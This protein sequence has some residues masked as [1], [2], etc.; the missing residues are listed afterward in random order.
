MESD[1]KAEEV[2]REELAARLA[3]EASIVKEEA[4]IVKQ[5]A[6]AVAASGLVML[7]GSSELNP[8]LRK[9][10]AHRVNTTTAR[11]ISKTVSVSRN[12]VSSHPEYARNASW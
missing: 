9:V 6:A 11:I 5:E 10:L 4:S 2:L 3:T 8:F 1:V 12:I 7:G